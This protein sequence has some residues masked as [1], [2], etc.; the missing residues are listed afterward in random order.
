MF[1]PDD[2]MFAIVGSIIL[3]G[4]AGFLAVQF[5][6]FV[7]SI[8]VSAYGLIKERIWS[9]QYFGVWLKSVVGIAVCVI[10]TLLGDYIF[11]Q[12]LG[13]SYAHL[14]HMIFWSIFSLILL[15]FVFHILR[16]LRK[17]RD[18]VATPEFD[19]IHMSHDSNI[20]D[21]V[22]KNIELLKSL[23]DGLND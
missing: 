12:R 22:R 16:K 7:L 21:Y 10:I 20:D 5:S 6:I 18:I 8:A 11:R 9:K 3:G 17:L 19:D 4:A 1:N 14:D 23:Q 13:Y 15:A 2:T